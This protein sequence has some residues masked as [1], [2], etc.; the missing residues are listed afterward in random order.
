RSSSPARIARPS[1]AVSSVGQSASLTP[2]KSEVRVLHRPPPPVI[3][4]QRPCKVGPGVARASFGPRR[5]ASRRNPHW[6]DAGWP[7]SNAD[8][9]VAVRSTTARAGARARRPRRRAC[10][11]SPGRARP[12]PG[13]S[14]TSKTGTRRKPRPPPRP[15][16][17]DRTTPRRRAPPGAVSAS[18]DGGRRAT[19]RRP[20]AILDEG[21]R[22]HQTRGERMTL[23]VI[24]IILI[25]IGIVLFLVSLYNGLVTRRNRIDE[26]YSQIEV[27]LKRRHD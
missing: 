25:I 22:R 15:E 23:P 21:P 13:P 14:S 20:R 8:A 18:P 4:P 7:V 3:R 6:E 12:A 10:W 5:V 2:R 11:T 1:R 19:L 24:I 26:A 27:Q 17:T 9:P 16:P